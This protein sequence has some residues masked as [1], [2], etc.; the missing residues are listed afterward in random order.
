MKSLFKKRRI[1]MVFALFLVAGNIIIF[2]FFDYINSGITAISTWIMATAVTWGYLGAAI[3]ALLGN[4][5]ILLPIPYVIGIFSIGTIPSLNP[6]LIGLVAG[7]TATT[8]ELSSYLLGRGMSHISWDV[9][10]LKQMDKINELINRRYGGFITVFV[11]AVTPIPDDML[12]IPL[13]IIKYPFHK[14]ALACFLG[15]TMFMTALAVAGMLYRQGI[16]TFIPME[17]GA[18]PLTLSINLTLVIIACYV[19]I[20]VDWVS[21]FSRLA[22]CNGSPGVSSSPNSIRD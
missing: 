2:L 13:G 20:R 18:D 6:F 16:S 8:G 12:Y 10:Q 14:T 9:K 17:G 1:D 21:V 15:K 7:V 19:V 11:F 4:F 22:R 3:I 5:T